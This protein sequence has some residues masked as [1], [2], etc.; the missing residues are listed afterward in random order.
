MTTTDHPI[1]SVQDRNVR[2]AERNAELQR[3]LDDAAK[4][5]VE[6]TDARNRLTGEVGQ[7]QRE[8][9]QVRSLRDTAVDDNARL[10]VRVDELWNHVSQCDLSFD[11]DRPAEAVTVQPKRSND[12]PGERQFADCGGVCGQEAPA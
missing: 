10:R 1:Q 6:L 5:M 7:L 12:D 11:D 8:L 3:T 4:S 9:A 2:L